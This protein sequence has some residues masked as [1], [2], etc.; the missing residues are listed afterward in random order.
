MTDVLSPH[1]EPV[2]YTGLEGVALPY[3]L[4]L[5]HG[6]E[7]ATIITATEARAKQVYSDLMGLGM[8][9]VTYFP[10]D[11][12]LPFEGVSPD[13]MGIAERLALRERLLRGCG[14]RWLVAPVSAVMGRWMTDAVFQEFTITLTVGGEIQ[15]DALIKTFLTNGYQRVDFIEDPGTFAV[16]GSVIDYFPP[17]LPHPLRV[18]LFGDEITSIHSFEITHQRIVSQWDQA[19]IF[20]VREILFSPETKFR[21]QA[22]LRGLGDTIEIPSRRL[23]N[24]VDEVRDENYF[25]GIEAL[26]PAF[27]AE[28]EPVFQ[29]LSSS[30]KPLVLVD[31]QELVEGVESEI[32]KAHAM[33]EQALQHHDVVL[34]VEDYLASADELFTF[35]RARDCVQ[36][37][38]LADERVSVARSLS[39]GDWSELGR[40]VSQRRDSSER[41]EILQPL[42]EAVRARLA[43]EGSFFIACHQRSNAE[44]L[45]ELLHQRRLDLPVLDGFPSG[46]MGE[47]SRGGPRCGIVLTT[48]SA[49]F[50]DREQ[51][52]S[53]ITDGDLF[54]VAPESRVRRVRRPPSD[55]LTTLRNLD[56]GDYIIHVDHGIGRY[57]GLKRLIVNGA[58]GDFVHLEYAGGDRLY[59]PVYR[60]NLLQRYRGSARH[61]RL[62]KLGGNRWM[63][64]KQRVKDSVLQIA[65][66]LLEVQARRVALKGFAVASPDDSFRAFEAAFP[67]E[68]TPDQLRAIN[69]VIEDLTAPCP[70]DRLICGD[71]GFGKTE[72]AIRGAFLSIVGGYQVG[73]LVP[74]TVLAEQHG[75]TFRE[76][77]EHEGVRVEVL[78]RFRKPREVAAILQD[79]R[80]GKVDILVG[81]HRLLSHDVVF[82]NL[83]LLV[84]DEEQRFGVRHK[85][86]IK[87]LRHSVNVLTM[88]ATPIPRTLHMA[89]VGIRNLSLITTPPTQRNAIRTEITRFDE[90]VIAEAIR[91][92]LHRGGQVFVVHNRVSSIE[93]LAQLVRKLVPEARVAVGHGQM[94]STQLERIMVDFVRR[95]SSVLICTAI[96]ESGID[97]PLAN[98]MII[99]RAD[100]FGLSQLHQLRGRIGRGARRAFAYLLLP[101]TDRITK[102]ATERL[103]VLKK[104]SDLGAGYHIATHDLDLR[105]PGDLLGADQSGNIAAVGFELFTELL[106]EA[107]ETVKGREVKSDVEPD[108]KLPV[109]A[110]LPEEYLPQPMQRLAYYQRMTLAKTDEEVYEIARE[111]R[112]I[113]GK[114]PAEA[115]HL[116]EVM[117][118]RRRLKHMGAMGLSAA[119]SGPGELKIGVSFVPEPRI[120]GAKLAS[121]LQ[122][123]RDRYRLT[124]TGRLSISVD[125][126]EDVDD[127]HF[128]R[129][130]RAELAELCEGSI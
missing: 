78:S 16:R 86:R 98:T 91:R 18:D 67:Y 63:K 87:Q 74:T 35:F 119:L 43:D 44:R 127:A 71:V 36:T 120:D 77:L 107:V 1:P 22:R 123:Q 108:I 56:E 55:G 24:M 12:H 29:V 54:G 124:P 126:P 7:G 30:V 6:E 89:S 4:V 111:I 82:K 92:E 70:M 42:V 103:A 60:L 122:T 113:Y 75:A 41:G 99:N 84:V 40:E 27:Y 23:N 117:I 19:S 58:D 96:I 95:E 50:D 79:C 69:E 25:F 129:L 90:G 20:P 51:G 114:P 11:G 93:A 32:E 15:R 102:E 45:R 80:E 83:G 46:W 34:E 57:L 64:T 109:T 52:V 73:V 48:L 39:L 106:G 8:E 33:R 101:R 61:A 38:K 68:E 49:G 9:G 3:W 28:T 26:W 81:T 5:E 88:S 125:T 115:E 118:I 2:V 104:F 72:V 10:A 21:C 121:L 59:L 14:P 128:L 47:E 116:T 65:H 31:A 94:S 17:A 112:E 97:I 66:Q 100:M 53:V 85:E 130:V 76:R 13:S 62:D 37:V 110:V 105:G